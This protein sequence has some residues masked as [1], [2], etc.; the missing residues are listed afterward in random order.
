MAEA[1]CPLACQGVYADIEHLN[2][3]EGQGLEE[4]DEYAD[5]L[6]DYYNYKTHFVSNY[7]LDETESWPFSKF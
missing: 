7:F 6:E 4:R 5:M 2:H 3:W 1:R